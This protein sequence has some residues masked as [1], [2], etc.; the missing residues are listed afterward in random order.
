MEIQLCF[1]T[2][3]LVLFKLGK[4]LASY[5]ASTDLEVYL[6]DVDQCAIS[7]N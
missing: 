4:M 6:S 3:D 2:D 1:G 5:F 7:L